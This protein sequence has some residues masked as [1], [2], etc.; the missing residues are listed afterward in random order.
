MTNI[1]DSNLVDLL[2]QLD[3][4][5]NEGPT[6]I[7]PNS[8]SKPGKVDDDKLY[9][10]MVI[11]VIKK[12]HLENNI[13]SLDEE[14]TEFETK[15]LDKKYKKKQLYLN[16]IIDLF[17]YICTKYGEIKKLSYVEFRKL[18]KNW[19]TD[20]IKEMRLFDIISLDCP[21]NEEIIYSTIDK[22]RETKYSNFETLI[23][24]KFKELYKCFIKDEKNVTFGNYKFD[25]GYAFKTLSDLKNDNENT[26]NLIQY[27]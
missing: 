1:E 23:N 18:L 6:E 11:D 17:N 3:D 15:P 21:E 13:M 24:S 9:N 14:K 10:F 8:D 5:D 27:K 25:L 7:T 26:M 20:E 19:N 22:E 2:N 16:S 4:E 12:N